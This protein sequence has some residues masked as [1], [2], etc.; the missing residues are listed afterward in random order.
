MQSLDFRT[1]L[2]SQ[3]PVRGHSQLARRKDCN[4]NRK[5]EAP[6]HC[7]TQLGIRQSYY[8]AGS[9]QHEQRSVRSQNR[10]GPT[11]LRNRETELHARQVAP[12]AS[13]AVTENFRGT[14]P[15]RARGPLRLT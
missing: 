15:S 10:D 4:S 14:A 3:F 1:I 2:E 9:S 6:G 13:S 12:N 7:E 5:R 8:N 11:E